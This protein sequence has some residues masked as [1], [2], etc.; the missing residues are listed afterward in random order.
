MLPVSGLVSDRQ[1]AGILAQTVSA[2]ASLF[3]SV[4]SEV[5]LEL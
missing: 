2:T 3:S 1:H 5:L 4:D